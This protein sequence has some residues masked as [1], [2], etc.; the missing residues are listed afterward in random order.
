[1]KTNPNN[2]RKY[3]FKKYLWFL[4]FCSDSSETKGSEKTSIKVK[5]VSREL[6]KLH[7]DIYQGKH[8]T[9]KRKTSTLKMRK[10]NISLA[11]Y[12]F[13]IKKDEKLTPESFSVRFRVYSGLLCKNSAWRYGHATRIVYSA[14]VKN[15]NELLSFQNLRVRRCKENPCWF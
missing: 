10:N 2:W 3:Q 13:S 8:L 12:L 14:V 4:S 1:M 15:L 6:I 11:D 9:L 5:Q 7:P